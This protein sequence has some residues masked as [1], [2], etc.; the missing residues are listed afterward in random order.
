MMFCLFDVLLPILLA[1]GLGDKLNE[2]H[3]RRLEK[4]RHNQKKPPSS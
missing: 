3:Q 2:I 4:Q 1:M